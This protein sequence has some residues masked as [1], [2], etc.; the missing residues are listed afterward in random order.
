MDRE[1]QW[2]LCRTKCDLL[3]FQCLSSASNALIWHNAYCLQCFL[4][5]EKVCLSSQYVSYRGLLLLMQLVVED[6]PRHQIPQLLA[7]QHL[8]S[9]IQAY[10]LL[11]TQY[12]TQIRIEDWAASERAALDLLK[13]MYPDD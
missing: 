8:Q 10:F 3:C 1:V 2:A 6:L 12:H 9:K 7:T 4:V 13:N 5:A 11:Q